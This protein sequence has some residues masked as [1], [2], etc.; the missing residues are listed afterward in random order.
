MA[1][2]LDLA[3]ELVA[4]AARDLVVVTKGVPD[5]EIPIEVLGFHCHQAVEKCIK[6]VLAM[7]QIEFRK[8][9]DIRTLVDLARDA[10]LE[11]PSAGQLD[12]LTP[13]AVEFR[14][15]ALPQGSSP[16][17][18]DR[19]PGL[20]RAVHEWAEA[21]LPA[22]R[23]LGSD[24]A[25]PHRD[26]TPGRGRKKAPGRKKA[27]AGAERSRGGRQAAKRRSPRRPRSAR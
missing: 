23:G 24:L 21:L 22:G 8:I 25:L 17:P 2:S 18:R 10:G 1:T 7:R 9:H 12:T 19:M 27:A 5:A 20:A 3:R 15:R 4:A 16:V 11:V 14:Y 6:A 26:A 13:F